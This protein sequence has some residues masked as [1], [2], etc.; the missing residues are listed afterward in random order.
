[1]ST[2]KVN[3]KAGILRNALQIASRLLTGRTVNPAFQ[4]VRFMANGTSLSVTAANELIQ[5]SIPLEAEYTPGFIYYLE[6][7]NLIYG[8]N[9]IA[10]D[11]PVQLEFNE[12]TKLLKG[13][14]PNGSFQLPFRLECESYPFTPEFPA[15][16]T[17]TNQL[18][19]DTLLSVCAL[20]KPYLSCDE[21]RPILQHALFNFTG[22]GSEFVGS[23][24][25]C[26]IRY[27][28]DVPSQIVR[29]LLPLPALSFLTQLGIRKGSVNIDF[30]GSVVRFSYDRCTVICKVYKE[31]RFPDY[32]RMFDLKG[33][34][35]L[36]F[37]RRTMMGACTR[38]SV[39]SASSGSQVHCSFQPGRFDPL[40]MQVYDLER[41]AYAEEQVSCD[42]DGKPLKIIFNGPMLVKCLRSIA[43]D[44]LTC[45]LTSESSPAI[46]VSEEDNAEISVLL[47]PMSA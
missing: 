28:L 19:S 23:D 3:I 44:T 7:A 14:Y 17:V 41:S 8:L 33:T 5:F 11:M 45:R 43:A 10:A 39:F 34:A 27:K 32:N 36:S 15:D 40:S 18:P 1:M 4:V 35:H 21:L 6:P 30:C 22:E 42:Y 25:A 26:L 37:D 16:K 47:M 13:R 31:C 29:F 24:G 12:D 38:A 20:V 2:V 9:E 46:F